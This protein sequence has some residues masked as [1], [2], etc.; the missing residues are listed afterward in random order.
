M[1]KIPELTRITVRQAKK[2]IESL[3]FVFGEIE[4]YL[5]LILNQVAAY[6]NSE[7]N[8]TAV[9]IIFIDST[10]R[11]FSSDFNPFT[12]EGVRKKLHLRVAK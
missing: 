9:F 2:T 7:S 8:K 1:V 11:S 10:S 3:G 4:Y 5:N 12:P 6:S